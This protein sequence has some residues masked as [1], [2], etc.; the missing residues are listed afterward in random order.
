M[1]GARMLE[2]RPSESELDAIDDRI[3]RL[4]AA[5]M[6]GNTAALPEYKRLNS[7]YGRLIRLPYRGEASR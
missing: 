1:S 7:E 2:L 5:Y 6:S 3:S 4:W